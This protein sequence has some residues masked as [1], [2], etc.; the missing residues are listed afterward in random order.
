MSKWAM[1]E[2]TDNWKAMNPYKGK[3]LYNPETGQMARVNIKAKNK[4]GILVPL[5]HH[6]KRRSYRRGYGRRGMRGRGLY[7]GTGGFFGDMWAKSQGLREQLGAMGRASSNPWAQAAGHAA[8]ALGIGD[9][10]TQGAAVANDIVDGGTGQGIPQFKEAGPSTVMFSHK[11][12][13]GDIYAPTGQGFQNTVYA[14]NPGLV[15]TFPW[16]SQ[17]AANYEE[18]T[19]H[20]LIFTFRSTVTDFNSGTGQVGTL[21]M[22]TQYNADDTPFGTKSDMLEYDLAM[23]GKTSQTMVHGVECDE[24]QN[25]GTTG[26]YVRN[27]PVASGEDLKLYDKGILNIGISNTPTDFDNQC[28][29]ELWVSYTI[30]LRKP[31]F[32]VS[33]GLTIARDT[34][35]GSNAAGVDY[36]I[37]L[38]MYKGQQNRIGGVL[39]GTTGGWL[40]TLPAA[41][42]GYLK[43]RTIMN[44]INTVGIGIQQIGER[45]TPESNWA[46]VKDM[47]SYT[48]TTSTDPLTGDDVVTTTGSW[49]NTVASDFPS[50]ATTNANALQLTRESHWLVTPPQGVATP[51]DNTYF[52]SLGRNPV[53]SSVLSCQIDVEVY[54]VQF[55]YANT[56]ASTGPIGALVGSPELVNR[57]TQQGA[58]LDIGV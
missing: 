14:I 39:S 26:K 28:L 44:V 6:N 55:N 42:N 47:V 31:R 35:I 50:T 34:F 19:M 32:A 57:S 37:F 33:R 53:S 54:N 41:F 4:Y 15:R 25:S 5:Q 12:Y 9:Y 49:T 45:A 22:A 23:S 7:T 43:I 24:A 10:T 27:G 18:Y 48:T 1:I 17:V 40:Y 30:S 8:S 38:T 2:P 46:P 16:L 51:V 21:I 52:V 58:Q 36:P 3:K 20:Q 29:G 56:D 11:E 13:I